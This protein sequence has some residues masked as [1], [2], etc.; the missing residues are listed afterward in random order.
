VLDVYARPYDSRYPVLCMDEQPMQLLK[1]TRNP[2][3]F[4]RK[5]PGRRERVGRRQTRRR[6][7]PRVFR[8][9]LTP[10]DMRRPAGSSPLAPPRNRSG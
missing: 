6:L 7:G 3:Q 5:R 8:R 4:R 9:F 2:L 10:H 1:E